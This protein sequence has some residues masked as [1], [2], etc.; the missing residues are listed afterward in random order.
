M[1]EWYM[2]I[3]NKI[4]TTNQIIYT[5]RLKINKTVTKLF[6]WMDGNVSLVK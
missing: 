4:Y 3:E 6:S 5:Q 1:N 2:N